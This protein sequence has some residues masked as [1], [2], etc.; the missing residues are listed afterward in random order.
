MML[1]SG[2][3]NIQ[4]VKTGG[5]TSFGALKWTCW[6][7]WHSMSRK[8]PLIIIKVTPFSPSAQTWAPKHHICNFPPTQSKLSFVKPKRNADW[9]LVSIIF[10]VAYNFLLLSRSL[11]IH[12]YSGPSCSQ[13]LPPWSSALPHT[14]AEWCNCIIKVFSWRY[15]NIFLA[16]GS[17]AI[18]RRINTE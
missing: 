1:K 6:W 3:K 15:G 9:G 2:I 17:T 5:L 16:C 7:R 8:A 12:G 14:T 10:W 4:Q 13:P 11:I 18:D